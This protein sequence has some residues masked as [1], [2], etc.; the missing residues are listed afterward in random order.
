VEINNVLSYASSLSSFFHCV[1]HNYAQVKFLP[2]IEQILLN[3]T[4]SITQIVCQGCAKFCPSALAI[5]TAIEFQELE[6]KYTILHSTNKC[7]FIECCSSE[8]VCSPYLSYLLVHSSC[9]GCLFSLDHTQTHTTVGS[10][11]LDEGSALHRD[12]YLKT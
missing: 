11:P 10:T 2:L 9:R 8:I 4:R 7:A 3:R 1:E 5:R 6:T 12:L